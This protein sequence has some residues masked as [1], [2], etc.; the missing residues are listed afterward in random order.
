MGSRE[1]CP[2][3]L[4][5]LTDKRLIGIVADGSMQ[6]QVPGVISISS[7]RLLQEYAAL[8]VC[9]VLCQRCGGKGLGYG[10]VRSLLPVVVPVLIHL[11]AVSQDIV[12]VIVNI[13]QMLPFQRFGSP[14]DSRVV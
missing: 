3:S 13:S 2:R 9:G 10:I 1:G 6:P 11:P 7:P 5:N 8:T 14:V 4:G 12:I